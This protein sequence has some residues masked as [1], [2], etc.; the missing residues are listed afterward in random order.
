MPSDRVCSEC[1]HAALDSSGVYCKFFG[2]QILNER[3]A[4]ECGQ[5]EV[6]DWPHPPAAQRPALMAVPDGWV[7]RERERT[8]CVQ[9]SIDYFGKEENGDKIVKN[10]ER[11]LTLHLGGN[12][13]M[14]R[15]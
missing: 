4:E 8:L 14:K 10:L 7:P 15:I 3:V 1:I 5:F 2:E 9:L 11:E 6:D 12:V 13:R